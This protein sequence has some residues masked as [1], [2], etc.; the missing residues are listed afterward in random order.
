MSRGSVTWRPEWKLGPDEFLSTGEALERLDYA[1][2]WRPWLWRKPAARV[3]CPFER[4]RGKRVLEFGHRYG[5]FSCLLAAAGADVTG[6]ELDEVSMEPA[7]EE[8][9]RWGVESRTNFLTY[10]GDYANLPPGKFDFIVSKSALVMTDRRILA[11]LFSALHERLAPGGVGL[12]VENCNNRVLQMIR[13]YF[14]HRY[15]TE[16]YFDYVS[17]GFSTG[18]I[19]MIGKAFGAVR[20]TKHRWLIWAIQAGE[21]LP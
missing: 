21:T 6:I 18:Q 10:D 8:A 16:S 14:V 11:D 19:E 2:E 9:K 15:V 17:W 5:R 1:L 3:L 4:F 12:F 13:R 7:R 20:A